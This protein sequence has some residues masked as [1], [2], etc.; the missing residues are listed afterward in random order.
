MPD[1]SL[2]V[3]ILCPTG[4]DSLLIASFLKNEHLDSL[5]VHSMNE[6]CEMDFEKA[7]VILIAEEALTTEGIET[8]NNKLSGQE[9]WS[10][11]PIVLLTSG[12]AKNAQFKLKRLEVFVTSGNVTLLERPLQPLTLMSATQVAVRARRRQY[13][14]RNLLV[15]QVAATKMRD[16]FISIASH[17]LKTPLTSLKL[18]TQ[19]A[20]RIS[21]RPES[22]SKRKN[23]EAVKLHDQPD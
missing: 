21:D 13:L 3:L 12:G 23:A 4:Q 7:G 11:I 9:A 15:D 6:L 5:I 20:R 16:E 17:E 1:R 18:Q 10:D 14:V 19:M 22:L 2:E 8:F